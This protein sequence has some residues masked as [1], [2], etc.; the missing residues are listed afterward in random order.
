MTAKVDSKIRNLALKVIA[1]GKNKRAITV[2]KM[3]LSKGSVTTDDLNDLGYN[4]PPRAVGDVRDAGIPIVTGNTISGK[5]GRRMAIYSFGDPSKIR[6]G[7]VGGRSA[8]PKAFKAALIA[9]YGSVDCITGAHLD[10]RV[11]QIDHRVPYRIAGDAGLADRDV[12]SYML[13]DGSSQRAKSWACEHCPNM[14]ESQLAK[15]CKS[16]FWASPNDYKHVATEQ[17]RRTDISWQGPDVTVHDRLQKKAKAMGT[18]VAEV[19]KTIVRQT[20]KDG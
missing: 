5:S 6:D 13:L 16:C 12:R 15:I 10:A 11:L 19:I 3:L 4:H 17:I 18:T 20:A 1:E 8:F 9:E 14:L 7:R 2:L